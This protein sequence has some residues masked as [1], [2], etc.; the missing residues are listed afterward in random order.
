MTTEPVNRLVS[1]LA[2]PTVVSML[3]T[4]LYNIV[5]AF[6]VGRLGPS[7]TGSIGVVYSLM[8]IIQAVGFGFGHGSGNYISRKL[9]ERN[10]REASVMAM[11]GAVSSF[12]FGLFVTITGLC[13]FDDVALWLGSTPTIKPYA[14]QYLLYILIGAPFFACSLTL[15]NQLRLQGNANRA[16]IGIAGGAV[17]NCLLDPLF[18][19]GF[20]MGVGGAGLSTFISQLFSFLILLYGTEK[21]DAVNLRYINFR[22]TR[23]RYLAILQGGAPSLCRQSTHSISTIVLNHVMKIYGDNFFAAMTVVLRLSNFIFAATAGIGQGFQPVC[24]FN[25]G[26]RLYGR[27]REAYLFTQKTALVML[28]S[29]TLLLAAFTPQ[30]IEQFSNVDAVVNI[31]IIIQRIQCI[32]IPFMGGCIISSM[33]FQNINKY[34]QATLIAVSRSGLFLIP[35]LLILPP[36]TGIWGVIVA[37]PLADLC[38]FSL[39]MPMQNVLLRKLKMKT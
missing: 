1:R 3:I 18:I 6:F 2:V 4:A 37:Q 33:L 30:I 19:F 39:A 26:A 20:N 27:V 35:I 10:V 38:T 31:G 5:D 16:M 23:A 34:K 12:L 15:N 17:L 21:S 8:A 29:L 9:G 14:E 22:P 11:V 25:Y 32:S 24:G 7:A 28:L 13:L 36:L